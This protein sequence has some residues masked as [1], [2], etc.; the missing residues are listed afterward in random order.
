MRQRPWVN[1][2]ISSLSD[3]MG[4]LHK[5][6][7]QAGGAAWFGALGGVTHWSEAWIQV[8]MLMAP[9]FQ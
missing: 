6:E 4:L 5:F 3:Q 2:L 9:P 7:A 1:K 8:S